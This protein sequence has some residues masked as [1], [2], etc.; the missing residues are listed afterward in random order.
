MLESLL[1]ETLA[2]TADNLQ[3]TVEMLKCAQEAAVELPDEARQKLN[4]VH[5]GVALAVEALE[6]ETLSQL[7]KQSIINQD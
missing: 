1:C 7:V 5:V 6:D 3:M 4:L 2:V